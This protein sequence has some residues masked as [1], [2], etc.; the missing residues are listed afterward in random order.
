M[1]ENIRIELQPNEN[2]EPENL[3]LYIYFPKKS[4]AIKIIPCLP[5][6]PNGILSL[7][8]NTIANAP[9]KKTSKT[10]TTSISY[11]FRSD[12]VIVEF[13]CVSII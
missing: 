12:A 6:I 5:G 2:K 1:F 9:S 4:K 13:L 3:E 11:A 10:L 7:A 8:C